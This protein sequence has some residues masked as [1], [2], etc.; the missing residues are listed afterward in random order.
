MMEHPEG[1][2]AVVPTPLKDGTVDKPS[3]ERLVTRLAPHVD[4]LTVLG[5]SGE[6]G[7]FSLAERQSILAAFADAAD[8]HR[9]PT[10]VGVTHPSTREEKA[11]V[12]CP[13]AAAASAFL[14]LPP[15]YYPATLDAAERHLSA[16][17][18]AAERPLVYYEIPSLSGLSLGPAEL[19]ALAEK[20][21]RIRA[22]K[23]S[24]VG[25]D[26]EGLAA[27][28]RLR[29]FAGYDEILHEQAAEGCH[30]VMAPVVALC[31]AACRRWWDCLQGGQR[32]RAYA[33]FAEEIA[34]LCW[35][36]VGPDVDFI[37]AVKR[38][39]RKQGVL[40]SDET[41]PGVPTLSRSR[42]RHVD[43]V[44]EHMTA[45]MAVAP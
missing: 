22:V 20:I 41:A 12:A 36:M 37:A 23:I 42:A 30:G 44:L 16:V 10:I 13:E 40:A 24:K 32:R 1:L 35:M 14:V 31:P 29:I 5:S 43:E 6:S 15:S 19:L 2:F 28:G 27:D 33:I 9:L 18:E 26:V 39:L 25:F 21:P 45:R 3:V 8:R 17:G 7:Y 11:F 38:V 34:P 4:G